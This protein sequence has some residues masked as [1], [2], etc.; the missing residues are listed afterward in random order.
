MQQFTEVKCPDCF[1]NP[2]SR[3]GIEVSVPNGDG[4][5]TKHVQRSFYTAVD[6]RPCQWQEADHRARIRRLR[7]LG[8]VRRNP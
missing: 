7:N 4:T 1:P 6:D 5:Y 2:F 8:K 3:G